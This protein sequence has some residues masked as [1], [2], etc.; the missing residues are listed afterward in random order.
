MIQGRASALVVPLNGNEHFGLA[1]EVR[2]VG[3][4]TSRRS[5]SEAKA[6]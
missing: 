2:L 6:G 4:Y 1:G 3:R 5:P